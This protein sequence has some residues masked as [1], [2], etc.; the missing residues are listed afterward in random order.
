[1]GQ[2]IEIILLRS[3]AGPIGAREETRTLTTTTTMTTIEMIVR[4]R[5]VAQSHR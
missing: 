4:S 5:A 1:M 2:E 3:T